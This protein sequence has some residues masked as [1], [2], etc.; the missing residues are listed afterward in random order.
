MHIPMFFKV[1]S[2][3]TDEGIMLTNKEALMHLSVKMFTAYSAIRQND[4]SFGVVESYL[5]WG[6]VVSFF[7]GVQVFIVL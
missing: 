1:L 3:G 7:G 2:Y 5:P 6:V 4:C